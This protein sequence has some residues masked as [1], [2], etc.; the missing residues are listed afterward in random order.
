MDNAS[1]SDGGHPDGVF[2]ASAGPGGHDVWGGTPVFEG[3]TPSGV[4]T[5]VGQHSAPS[6]ESVKQENS[7]SSNKVDD[8]TY[9][10]LTEEDVRIILETFR[11]QCCSDAQVDVEYGHMLFEE[12]CKYQ[13][14]L[15][16]QRKQEKEE[17]LNCVKAQMDNLKQ[18]A[19]KECQGKIK[20]QER[21]E[22]ERK[23]AE[24]KKIEE[25]ERKKQLQKERE[26]AYFKKVED[27][28]RQDYLQKQQEEEMHALDKKIRPQVEKKLKEEFGLWE[29]QCLEMLICRHYLLHYLRLSWK[30]VTMEIQNSQQRDLWMMFSCVHHQVRK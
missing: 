22:N 12:Y 23:E 19:E 9:T 26:E 7:K 24:R 3:M 14:K 1:T 30:Q 21:L 6:G 27:E 5:T 11:E 10:P 18:Q 17:K 25:E 2:T 4:Q 8:N 13:D 20:E 28:L 15:T 29:N 16:A